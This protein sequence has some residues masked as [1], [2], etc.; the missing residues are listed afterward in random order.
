MNEFMTGSSQ[1]RLTYCKGWGLH[2]KRFY[3]V[4]GLP[5]A[6]QAFIPEDVAVTTYGAGSVAA[7]VTDSICPAC[8][9]HMLRRVSADD[10]NLAAGRRLFGEAEPVTA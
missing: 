4:A 8:N 1:V 6:E 3:A 10:S 9:S 7:A 2:S 5:A